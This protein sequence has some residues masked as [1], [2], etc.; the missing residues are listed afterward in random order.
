MTRSG[1][2]RWMRAV[3]SATLSAFTCAVSTVRPVRSFT[4]AAMASHLALVRLASTISENTS[5]ACAH[6]C[7]ATELTPPAPMIRTFAISIS[8]PYP[9]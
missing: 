4:P 7:V 6:L 9:Y 1:F 5:A 2:T 3:V 8:F